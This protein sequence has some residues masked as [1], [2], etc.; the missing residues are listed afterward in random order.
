ME[1]CPSSLRDFA[2]RN[3]C[4]FE[5]LAPVMPGQKFTMDENIQNSDYQIIKERVKQRPLNRK[6]LMR[7]MI[8][9]A[10]MAVVFGVLAC[11]TFIFLQPVFSNILNPTTE[12]EPIEIP[13]DSYE[14]EVVPADMMLE[15]PVV[16]EPQVTVIE[17]KTN[18]DPMAIYQD[19]YENLYKIAQDMKKSLV[20]VTS[21]SQDVDWFDNEYISK[22]S[23]AGLYIVNNGIQLM[24]LAHTK[25]IQ[26]AE[27]IN[28]TFYDGSVAAGEIRESDINTGLSVISVRIDEISPSTFAGIRTASLANSRVSN[29]LA[30]PVIAMGQIFGGSNVAV[31]YGI[32]TTKGSYVNLIDQNYEL[33]GTNI[34]GSEVATGIIANLNGDVIGI[35]NQEYNSPETKNMLSAIGISDLK[36]TIE[37]MSNARSRAYM[38][39]LGMDVSAEAVTQGVPV[40]AYVTTVEMGS[41]AMRAGIQSGDVIIGIGNNEITR[42]SHIIDC[43]TEINPDTTVKVKVMRQSGEEYTELEFEVTLDEQKR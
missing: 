20:T 5:R 29:I 43:I 23:S 37:R 9:T 19:Q 24:I 8:I 17:H 40:G 13:S 10:S 4:R 34:Y 36:K 30:S 35:I 32:V 2:Q 33:I 12:P 39:I 16:V 21:V 1:E 11:F 28:I 42:F 6:K 41:P 26:D 31:N 15:E 38:G 3:K 25:A 18:I 22:N 14:D 7:R 27:Q